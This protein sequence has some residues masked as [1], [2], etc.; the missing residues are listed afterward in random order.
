MHLYRTIYDDIGPFLLVLITIVG[1]RLLSYWRSFIFHR[2]RYRHVET[3]STDEIRRLSLP[4][5]K[6][7]ITTRGSAGSTEVIL[8]GIRN[9]QNLASEDPRMYGE[10]LSVELVTESDTQ[11]AQIE[12]SFAALSHLGDISGHS[13]RIRD[14][15]S[16]EVKGT[17]VSISQ[18]N[19]AELAGTRKV[20]RRGLSTMT[21]RASCCPAN[22]ASFSRYS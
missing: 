9:V 12:R 19:S 7:Q 2:G 3:V 10:V 1:I 5:V 4:F 8:R 15:E 18:P 14:T 22:F 16:H 6:V 13:R 21:K 20:A 17:R 11:A